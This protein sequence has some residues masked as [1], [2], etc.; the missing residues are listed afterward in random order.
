MHYKWGYL[1]TWVDTVA[2]E[3]A[4]TTANKYS[5]G[6]QPRKKKIVITDSFYNESKKILEF[7]AGL[8]PLKGSTTI[9][10]KSLTCNFPAIFSNLYTASFDAAYNTVDP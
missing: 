2:H 6:F 10:S 5:H 9:F 1:P 8:Q 3:C 4:I 7:K